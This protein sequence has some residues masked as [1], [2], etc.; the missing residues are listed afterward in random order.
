MVAIAPSQQIHR[1]LERSTPPRRK[2]G[3]KPD[4][5]HRLLGYK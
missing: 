5:L 2:F 4:A 1:N 3:D